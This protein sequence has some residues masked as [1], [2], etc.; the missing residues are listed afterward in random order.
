MIQEANN[1]VGGSQQPRIYEGGAFHP[2]FPNGRGGGTL[3][4]GSL[5]VQFTG[6]AGQLELPLAGLNITLGGASDRIIFFKHPSLPDT[7]LHTADH[8]ILQEAGITQRPEL[9]A[10]VGKVH[11]KKRNNLAVWASILAV[12]VA[13]VVGLFAARDP[14]VTVVTDRIPPEWEV[15]L[16]ETVFSSMTSGNPPIE[17]ATL[18][19]HLAALTEP[20]LKGVGEQPYPF[21]FHII[22]DP[23][24]NAFALP[25]GHVVIHSEL[26]LKAKSAEEVAGVLA[27]EIAHVTKRH[28]VRNVVKSAGTYF[29]FQFLLGDVSD[30]VGV[31]SSNA[32]YLLNQKHSR[33]YEREADETGWEYLLKADVNP[34]GMISFFETLAHEHDDNPL[35]TVQETLAFMSTHPATSERIARL[36]EKAKSLPRDKKYAGFDL[37]F[38]EFQNTLRAKL[39]KGDKD[40]EKPADKPNPGKKQ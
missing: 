39:K 21:K 6:K 40:T 35:A 2:A 13:L 38:V 37:N 12:I 28:S 33:D 18:Q 22:E 9:Q 4:V 24:I 7:T 11:G 17:D 25:G 3:L 14:L 29:L 31:F 34:R 26:I 30:L 32:R 1:P 36:E 19:K 15:K 20:L 23:T 10:Q 8:A 16:G 27:H 5:A